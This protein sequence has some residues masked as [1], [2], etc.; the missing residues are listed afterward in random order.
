MSSLVVVV[1][2]PTASGKSGLALAVA[3]AF[4][5]TVINADSVQVYKELRI[6]SNRPSPSD[7]ARSPHRLFGTFDAAEQCSV[8]NWRNL[9]ITEISAA[10]AE[11]RLPIVVGGTGL[12][13]KALIE[14]LSWMPL[15]SPETRL[16]LKR[17][18]VE[19]GSAA[20]HT[21]LMVRDPTAAKRLEP[22][23]SQRVMRAL[24][25]LE[26]TGHSITEFQMR[27]KAEPPVGLHFATILLRPP[28][29]RLYKRCDERLANMVKVGVVAEVRHFLR[30]SPDPE[31][32]VMKALGLTEFGAYIKGL[33]P[34]DQ[35]LNEAQQATRRYAKRQ[36]TWFRTQIIA[37]FVINEQYSE[38]INE[39]IFSFIRQ[40]MLTNTQ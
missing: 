28:R 40:N 2:G 36:M 5:G 8:A 38:R 9:A 39:K 27:S 17:R 20:L 14:G 19:E 7:E 11:N 6:L 1:A 4:S 24:E 15:I 30:G 33:K 32:P 31:L 3:D 25:V 22:G 37:D 21:E 34:L 35:A 16:H 18:L 23:D 29:D 13:L 26:A 12:Y 10:H